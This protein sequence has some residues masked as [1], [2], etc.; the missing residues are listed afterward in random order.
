[1]RIKQRTSPP[2]V[3]PARTREEEPVPTGAWAA[4]SPAAADTFRA[5]VATRRAAVEMLPAVRAMFREVAA[6]RRAAAARVTS[7]VAAVLR[8]AAEPR[9]PGA[10][11][12][13]SKSS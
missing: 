13:A 11:P 7:R 8:A 2:W 6:T 4:M 12:E 10:E 1:M 9:E 3:D 5:A